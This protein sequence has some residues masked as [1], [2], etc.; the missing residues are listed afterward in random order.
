[1]GGHVTWEIPA[2]RFTA[3]ELKQDLENGTFEMLQEEY[4]D[5][6]AKRFSQ[7]LPPKFNVRNPVL[8]N[9]KF[10]DAKTEITDEEF[11]KAKSLPFME[12]VGTLN[13]PSQYTKIECQ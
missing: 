11:D 2:T 1:M 7:Y 6:A 8:P 10:P 13:Y 3:C 4:W 12:L 5:A 9:T